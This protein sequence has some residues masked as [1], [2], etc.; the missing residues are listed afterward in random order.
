MEV[1]TNQCRNC[2]DVLNG[3]YCTSCGQREGRGDLHFT[4]AATDI[5]GDVF[6]WDSRVWRTLIPLLIRPGFLSAEFNAGRRMRYMPPFRLY[7]VVSF[8]M[9]LAM[10]FAA[11]EAGFAV[12]DFDDAAVTVTLDSDADPDEGEA[13]EQTASAIEPG[14]DEKDG[15]DGKGGKDGKDGKGFTINV[16]ENGPPWVE[17]LEKRV[18]TNAQR[19]ADS[20]N[21]YIDDLME[22]LPQVMFVMLPVFALLLKLSYLF[23]P[24]HYLQ[25]LVFALHY[26]TF[27]YLLYLINTAVEYLTVYVDGLFALMLI[28]YLPL[29]LRRTYS[30]SWFGAIGKSVVL[31]FSYGAALLLGVATTAFVVLAVM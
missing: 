15:E 6:T 11:G 12:D 17:E 2:G 21:D 4:E 23:S 20:P 22:H 16:V 24:Y 27:V 31:M 14:E 30:S 19:V 18:E 1:T 10:S 8:L 25:H 26:H 13:V 3:Q 9:F 5:L 29:A 7:I 28:V